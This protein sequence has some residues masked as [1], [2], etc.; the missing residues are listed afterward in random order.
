MGYT[1][2]LKRSIMMYIDANLDSTVYWIQDHTTGA[3]YEYEMALGWLVFEILDT[4]WAD[5]LDVLN[6]RSLYYTTAVDDMVGK[7]LAEM[8]LGYD[9]SNKNI[10]PVAGGWIDE[11]EQRLWI[12]E[13][14]EDDVEGM[15]KSQI[16]NMLVYSYDLYQTTITDIFH[17][18]AI[19][20]K[21]IDDIELGVDQDVID[22]IEK[23]YQKALKFLEALEDSAAE[24]WVT[25]EDR[26]T[27]RAQEVFAQKINPIESRIH[28][29]EVDTEKY[30]NI[31][32]EAILQLIEFFL[33]GLEIPHH[34]VEDAT[35]GIEQWITDQLKLELDPLKAELNAV[36]SIIGWEQ[37][38]W[39]DQLKIIVGE[40][41]N[42][43]GGLSY[44]EIQGMI[45][46]AVAPV[47]SQVTGVEQSLRALVIPTETQIKKWIE[48]SDL[49]VDIFEYRVEIDR[50]LS[51]LL[52]VRLQYTDFIVKEYITQNVA[53]LMVVQ[54][55]MFK[56]VSA[57]QSFLTTDMQTSLTEIV[58]AFGTPEALLSYLVNAPEGQEEPMLDLMQLLLTMTFERGLL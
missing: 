12:L 53:D 57:I 16:Q 40:T 6:N 1:Y 55:T 58:E 15:T 13:Q 35:R 24:I 45:N 46:A 29:L 28:D 5:I 51:D 54:D 4:V 49:Y 30:R 44:A 31:F 38:W 18:I 42:G 36:V 34:N 32:Y 27:A 11:I 41:G 17:D 9:D 43:N 22:A 23:A 48:E 47:Q 14:G 20:N 3:W 25:I 52:S 8:G 37:Q 33:L 21:R 26:V 19:V 39:I 56:E 50:H 7:I 10:Y 2:E